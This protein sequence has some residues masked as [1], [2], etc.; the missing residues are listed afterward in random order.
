MKYFG[1]LG[2]RTLHNLKDDYSVG[3]GHR[4]DHHFHAS[5]LVASALQMGF[6]K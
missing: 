1:P 4:T 2:E 6:M 5:W 3:P